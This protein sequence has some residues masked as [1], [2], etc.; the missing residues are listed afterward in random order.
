VI[1]LN[2]NGPRGTG[3]DH[4]ASAGQAGGLHRCGGAKFPFP[5]PVIGRAYLPAN[6]RVYGVERKDDELSKL[7][8]RC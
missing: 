1:I 6:G 4:K 5:S 2:G 8:V 3:E 7:L